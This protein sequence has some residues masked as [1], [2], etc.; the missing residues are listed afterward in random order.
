MR[1]SQLSD[2]TGVPVV[3]IKHYLREGLV[4]AGTLTSRT[5]ATYGEGHVRRI[6]LVRALMDAGLST[7]RA[8]E[9]L[10]VVDDPPVS[11]A[12]LLGSALH[13]A[14]P[15]SSERSRALL[16][17]IGWDAPEGLGAYGELEQ[18]LARLE[19]A[20][21]AISDERLRTIAAGV[22]AIAAVEVDG[23]PTDSAEAAVEYAVVGTELVGPLI[24]ALRKVAH[25]R[26]SLARF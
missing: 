26:R 8:R 9:V 13:G 3:T 11:M 7:A 1:I 15:P 5:Q 20:G 25:A 6:R 18:A 10:A 12:E 21:F 2:A 23:V 19:Q 17:T 22:D 16:A 14:C 4:P 24:L